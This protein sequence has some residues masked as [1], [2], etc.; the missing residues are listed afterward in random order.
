MKKEE[1][2]ILENQKAS[3][4]LRNRIDEYLDSLP[5]EERER[6]INNISNALTP[7]VEASRQLNETAEKVSTALEPALSSMIER[8]R[9]YDASFSEAKYVGV[10]LDLVLKQFNGVL[11][12]DDICHIT[13]IKPS[14]MSK[15]VH[16]RAVIPADKLLAISDVTGVSTDL[17]LKQKER[18]L[19][20]GFVGADVE[21]V[22]LDISTMKTTKT[23]EIFDLSHNLPKN[24]IAT[25]AYRITQKINL[26]GIELSPI[27][28]V[29]ESY[30]NPLFYG[31]DP[32]LAI[33]KVKGT[34]VVRQV[35]RIKRNFFIMV[36]NKFVPMTIEE[37][38]QNISGVIVKIIFDF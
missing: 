2:E 25:R 36:E 22:D 17:L 31:N 14:A 5:E 12:I 1:K 30:E 13:G 6:I 10:D 8:V 16:N 18:T 27:F 3:E 9:N 33:V 32:F 24:L 23:G 38:K 28:I 37:L 35:Q 26:Y 20:D 34:H 29:D 11:S 7:L 21:L 15:Y 19:K 4:K